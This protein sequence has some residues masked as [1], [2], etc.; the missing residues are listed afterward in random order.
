MQVIARDP[1]RVVVM[2]PVAVP[3]PA[4]GAAA[5][6]APAAVEKPQQ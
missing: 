4:S 2:K 3:A 5:P 6:A 1:R